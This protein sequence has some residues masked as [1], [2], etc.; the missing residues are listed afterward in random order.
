MPNPTA[1]EID[2][3]IMTAL[4][5][6]REAIGALAKTVGLLVDEIA[7]LGTKQCQGVVLISAALVESL[8]ETKARVS[9]LEA[10]ADP[11][12]KEALV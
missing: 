4:E 5:L 8:I 12:S 9:E 1:E 3:E 7:S 11:P 10:S 6:E 2:E